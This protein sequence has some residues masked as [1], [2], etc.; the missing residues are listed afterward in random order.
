MSD[1]FFLVLRRLRAP[2]ILLI[3]VFAVATLGLTLIPGVD[4]NGE[5]WRMSFFHAFYFVSF[6]GSTIGFGEIP[7]AFTDAQRAWVLVCIYISVVSWLYAIGNI[8]RLLQDPTFQQAIAERSF[9]RN[10]GRLEVPFYIICGYGETGMLINRGLSEMG[11]PTVVID[12]N[13]DQT[14]SIELEDLSFTPIVLTADTTEP[15]NLLAAGLNHSNCNGVIAV[16]END[17]TNLQIAVACKL[18]NTRVQVIC[19]SEIQDEAENMASFGT[20]TIINP[21]LTFA[22]RLNLLVHNP[23]LHRIQN[24]FINQ[25]SAEYLTERALPKGR[26]VVCGYG[27]LGKAIQT[28]LRKD[29]IELVIV[30]AEP[31]A[32]GAPEGTIVGRGTEAKTLHEAGIMDATVVVAAT[33]DDA[34]NLSIL[35]TAQQIN[36]NIYTIGRVNKEANQSLFVQAKCDYIMRRS[37]LVANE[38][39]TT[40]SRPLVS[41]FIKYS[42]SLSDEDTNILHDDICELTGNRDPITWRLVL[43]EQESPAIVRHLANGRTL[44]ISQVSHNDLLE[45]AK[46]IPLLLLRGGVSH[47]LPAGKIELQIGDE[48]LFC[49][50][51]YAHNMAQRLADNTELIDSLINKNPHHIPLFRWLSRRKKQQQ[52]LS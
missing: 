30:E 18:L 27:R 36:S 41:K 42:S 20:D 11:I 15:N 28:H 39:L 49:L 43:D 4:P 22:A 1:V 19:R 45:N 2:L 34:N 25:Q 14:S 47:L 16:T 44:T 10:I 31:E 13:A 38:V 3:T 50:K 26:W 9:Q 46:C 51:R 21:Y 24:W 23:S 48:V 5:P 6:M 52:E 35:I 33:D 37:Q 7:Y 8:I 32:R 17:H 29:G 40:I 12:Y